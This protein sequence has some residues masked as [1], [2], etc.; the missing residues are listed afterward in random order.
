MWTPPGAWNHLLANGFEHEKLEHVS[1]YESGSRNLK[2]FDIIVDDGVD[3][4]S[5]IK[6]S[7]FLNVVSFGGGGTLLLFHFV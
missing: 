5:K 7:L 3:L 1:N 6:D 4:G 2:F